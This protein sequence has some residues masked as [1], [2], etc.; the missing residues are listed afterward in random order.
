[1]EARVGSTVDLPYEEREVVLRADFDELDG[2]CCWV[3][4][5][6]M[7][8][9]RHPGVGDSVY[10]LDRR[11]HGCMADIVQVRGWQARVKPNWSTWT[12]EGPPP[13]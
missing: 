5:R 13:A 6:F 4:M 9:P 7:G 11:G 12:G 2:D 8:G 1:M 10:L 3:S